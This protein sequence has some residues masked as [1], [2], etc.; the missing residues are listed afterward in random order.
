MQRADS[1]FLLVLISHSVSL[2][3]LF[4]S[5]L[6]LSNWVIWCQE[7]GVN[8]L[9]ITPDLTALNL[10]LLTS[11]EESVVLSLEHGILSK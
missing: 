4:T 2:E 1:G 6:T 10:R 8:I 7:Q 3:W 9:L 5:F 11:N